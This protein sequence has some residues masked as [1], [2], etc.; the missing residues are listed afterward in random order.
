MNKYWEIK[1]ASANKNPEL[2]I[3][4]FIGSFFE[5]EIGAL[6]IHN[7]LKL[8]GDVPELDVR[9][10]SKGGDVFEGFAIYNMLLAFK[11]K[12]NVYIDGVAAS[13]ASVIAMAG[14]NVY[15]PKNASMM[16]HESS[17][18]CF[19][20]AQDMR[21]Q[22]EAMDRVN[23]GIIQAYM[24]KSGMKEADAKKL[25]SNGD[26]WLTAAEAVEKGLADKVIEPVKAAAFFHNS[27]P[28][29]I[30]DRIKQAMEEDPSA[31][32]AA[33]RRTLQLLEAELTF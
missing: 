29:E 12:I 19:G 16:V 33:R 27:M 25:I 14:D 21:A 26:T 23:A 28:R 3:Y 6:Q 9:I 18:I 30:M 15:M 22:A 4:K 11:A 1:S 2:L 31:L 20:T 13:I 5:D 32:I 8:L 24:D 17:G 7:E 10:N